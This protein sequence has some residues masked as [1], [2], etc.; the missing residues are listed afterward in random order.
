MN[1]IS[2]EFQEL[3]DANG[4]CLGAFLGLEAWQ[5]VRDLVLAR[6]APSQ[7]P[8]PEVEEPLQDWSD[9]VQFWD[10]KYPVDLDVQCSLCGNETNDWQTDEPRKFRLTAANLGGL[11]TF[12]CLG[13]QAKI[14]KRH[15]KDTIKIEVKPFLP[16]KSSRNMG[17]PD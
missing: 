3:F 11:V 6:F 17:R 2:P 16:A 10:F 4:Q 12:R 13:C 15:F 7:A 8:A 14:M 5:T 1:P 9:L